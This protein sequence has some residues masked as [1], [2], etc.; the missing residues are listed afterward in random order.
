MPPTTAA[1]VCAG[2]PWRSRRRSVIPC[3]FLL[4]LVLISGCALARPAVSDE[5]LRERMLALDEPMTLPATPPKSAPPAEVETSASTFAVDQVEH[6]AQPF[7]LVQA[8]QLGYQSNPRLRVTREAIEQARGGR[9]TAFA[10]FLPTLIGSYRYVTSGNAIEGFAGSD[11]PFVVGFG[12]GVDQFQLSELRLQWTVWDFGRTL[13]HFEQASLRTEIA[14]L[15][16]QRARQTVAFDVTTAYFRV[17]QARAARTIEEQA[18]RRAESLLEVARNLLKRGA[19]DKND[20]LRAEVQLGEA[21]QAQVSA[22]S[23]EYVA[24]AGLNLAM[25]INVNTPVDVLEQALEPAFEMPLAA[26]LQMAADN[27]REF[28]VARRSINV[29]EQGLRTVKADFLPRVYVKGTLAHAQ[30]PGDRDED[31]QIGGFHIETGLFEGGRR[32]GELRTAQASVRASVATAQQIAD[33]IAFEV[34]QAFRGIDDA[35]QRL[36]LTR[37]AIAQAEENLR[38]VSNKY[39]AGDATPTDVVD[40]ETTM[41]RAQQK[42]L[43]A[44]YDYQTS[45][46]RLIYAMG[47]S[48]DDGFPEFNCRK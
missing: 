18:V 12:A 38:L 36:V 4:P 29:A 46:A 7:N 37:T 9:I 8:I 3:A 34:N 17:L 48:S 27:R 39:K 30:S 42:V 40:A 43:A 5:T 28:E 22:E 1:F 19:V 15:Q 14:A 2:L 21:K 24:F 11:V 31:V 32:L 13:G 33:N 20:V 25:G 47:V 23:A 45:L 16:Y 10:P 41:T 6:A 35:R 26:C 44:L